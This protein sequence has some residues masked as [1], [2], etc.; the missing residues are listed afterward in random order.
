[1]S[2]RNTFFGRNRNRNRRFGLITVSAETETETEP[3]VNV[4]KMLKKNV[5]GQVF[6]D[7][8]LMTHNARRLNIT[9][10]Y[11]QFLPLYVNF[12]NDPTSTTSEF[13]Y[14]KK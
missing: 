1:M 5:C 9:G 12:Y 14:P 7:I 10:L 11:V 3:F 6:S 4:I 8:R 13:N 2:D